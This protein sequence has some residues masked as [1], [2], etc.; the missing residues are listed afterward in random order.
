MPPL[1]SVTK[2]RFQS[3]MQF[4]KKYV[5]REALRRSLILAA[6]LATWGAMLAIVA[7]VS[8][9]FTVRTTIS[10]RLVQ[11]PDLSEKTVQEA[12]VLLRERGLMN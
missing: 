4:L 8:A 12:R 3:V 7:A 11:V 5:E 1:R 10:G 6:K 9:Y 2:L